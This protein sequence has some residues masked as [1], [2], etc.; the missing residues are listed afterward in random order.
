MKHKKILA[1]FWRTGQ[2]RVKEDHFPYLHT[3]E[4]K[5][6]GSVNPSR[7]LSAIIV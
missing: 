2:S 6:L 4:K 1:W 7:V 5:N 3:S